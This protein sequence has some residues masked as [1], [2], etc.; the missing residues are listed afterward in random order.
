MTDTKDTYELIRYHNGIKGFN[1]DLVVDWAIHLMNEGNETD[2]VLM[3]AS[4]SKPVSS[5]EIKPYLSAVLKDMGIEEREGVEAIRVYI[6]FYLRKILKDESVKDNLNHLYQL[7]I[8]E[9]F[10][11]TK[12]KDLGLKPFYLL[13]HAWSC[14][15]EIGENFYYEGVHLGNIKAVTKKEAKRWIDKYILGIAESKEE[16]YSTSQL[17]VKNKEKKTLLSRIKKWMS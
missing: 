10:I 6:H 9:E 12:S 7:F 14:L 2:N 17:L 11:S 8:D 5:I 13:Y 16:I 15:E 3:L 4:F 1:Y